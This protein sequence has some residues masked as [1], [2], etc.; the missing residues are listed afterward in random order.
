MKDEEE[1]SYLFSSFILP[2]SSFA[3][4]PL[5]PLRLCGE[6][7]SPHIRD[8]LIIIIVKERDLMKRLQTMLAGLA[9]LLACATSAAA[10]VSKVEMRIDGYLCGN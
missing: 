7:R 9:L 10:Q 4:P 3:L 2:P 5:R 1:A 8:E 6:R